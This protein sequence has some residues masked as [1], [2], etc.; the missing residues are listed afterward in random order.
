MHFLNPFSFV[1]LLAAFISGQVLIA[2]FLRHWRADRRK[3][4]RLLLIPMSILFTYCILVLISDNIVSVGEDAFSVPNAARRTLDLYRVMYVWGMLLLLGM[5]HFGLRYLDSP[6]LRGWRVAWLYLGGIALCHFFWSSSF[7]VERTSPRDVT[8][9]WRTAVPWQPEMGTLVP[10]FIFLWF[11]INSYFQYQFWRMP[12]PALENDVCLRSNIVWA[13]FTMWGMTGVVEIGMAASGYAGVA[14]TPVIT[15][16]SMFLLMLGLE[17]EHTQSEEQRKLVTR[18]FQ[19]YVDPALVKYVME[20]PEKE[21]IEGEV[22]E[23]TVVFTD[24]EGFTPLSERLREGVVPLLNEYLKVMT[25][26]IRE[27]NGYRNKWLGDGMMFFYGAPEANPDH[28]IHAVATVLKM[29]EMMLTFNE[30][31]INH[32]QYLG[33][34]LLPLAMRTGV[35]TGT[36]IVGD[37]GPEDACD[38]TTIGN[39]VNLGARLESANKFM[40]TRILLSERTVNLLPRDL[41]LIR[42]IGKLKL[43]GVTDAVMAFEP[44]ALADHATTTQKRCEERTR[45]MVGC[46]TKGDFDGCLDAEEQ[47]TSEIGPTKLGEV[48]RQLC[49]QYLLHAPNAGFSGEIVLPTK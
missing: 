2:F 43:V 39:A 10:A 47:M 8:S 22:R 37:A 34:S 29:Q 28:A 12:K 14:P 48:Y 36:M 26:L 15:A 23:M 32:S 49:G 40:G 17:E 30:N 9:S 27:H 13:G 19:S 11:A 42:P 3:R 38:Y 16:V 7:L 21:H 20:H 45:T 31:L 46:F 44:L 18:R 35:S 6:H 4:D 5:A 33:E 1:D 41:F 25:P 24:L